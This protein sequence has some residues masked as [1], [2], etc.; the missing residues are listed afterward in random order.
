[1]ASSSDSV[2]DA[3]SS[4]NP[5]GSEGSVGLA[6]EGGSPVRR[7]PWPTYEH[8]MGPFDSTAQQVVSTVLQSGRLFRY[9]TRDVGETEAGRLEQ[10][11]RD[12]FGSKHALALTSGTAAIAVALMALDLPPGSRI[13]CPAFGFPATASAIM[14]AGHEPALVA[15]DEN[16]HFDVDDL[17]ARFSDGL[18]AIVLVHMRGMAGP[19]EQVLA[20]AA[21][22]GIPVIEDAVPALGCRYEGRLLGTFGAA[23][24]FSMQS[25]KTVNTGEG[26][27]L[28]TDDDELHERAVLLAGAFEG[29]H[30]F[31]FDDLDHRTGYQLPLYNFRIDELRSAL[32]H[33]QLLSIETRVEL[34]RHHYAQ[35]SAALEGLTAV[36]LRQPSVPDAFLGESLVFFVDPELAEWVAAAITAEGVAARN[37]GSRIDPNARAF[38][39]WE[40]TGAHLAADEEHL[41]DTVAHLRGAIDI[42]L[43][44]RLERRDVDDCIAAVTKVI[45]TITG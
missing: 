27:F 19:V 7:R 14:L 6:V 15:V 17:R 33:R 8:G 37:F 24:C 35:V 5:A 44:Y 43:S 42:S 4:L 20:Y 29:R 1:M 11:L 31:H 9:D 30:R 34:M 12:H 13:A 2:E 45:E 18:A 26:G 21:D 16:L 23:G 22:R 3:G 40:F 10:A 38:W 28:L 41:R 32:A 25:D 39:T 36:R